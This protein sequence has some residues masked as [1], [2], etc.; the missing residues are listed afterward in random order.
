[1][2]VKAPVFAPPIVVSWT[3]VYVG[4][5]G[6]FYRADKDW[7][8]T[9]VNN[10]AGVMVPIVPATTTGHRVTGGLFGGQA[11]FNFQTGSWVWGV[12][13]QWSGTGGDGSSDCPIPN[14]G[15]I[16]RTDV[17]WLGTAAGRVGYAWGSAL[18]FGKGGFAWARDRYDISFATVPTGNE[19][20]TQDRTGWMAG[21]GLE[22]ALSSNWSVKVEYDY[23]NFGTDS[24]NLFRCATCT[25]NGL[26][27]GAL[28]ETIDVRQRIHLVKFGINYRFGAGPVTARY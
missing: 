27:G 22:Y 24:A 15:G 10:G 5:H 13:A 8:F 3:G 12:E 7:S 2:P 20:G 19:S 14:G 1:M 6:G 17:R 28:D 4:V 26:P 11:G 23:L 21:A 16:C 18:L 9:S 25:A